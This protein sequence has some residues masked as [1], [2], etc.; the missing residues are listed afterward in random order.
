MA[1]A[2]VAGVAGNAQ[3]GPTGD[4]EAAQAG[5]AVGTTIGA[6]V[7]FCIWAAGALMLGV[8]WVV[9]RPRG[10]PAKSNT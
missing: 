8:V 4:S 9:T 3:R 6:G 7:L 1:L 5:Y 10:A 2:I